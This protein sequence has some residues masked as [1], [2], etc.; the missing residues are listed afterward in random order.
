M[1]QP[2]LNTDY[3]RVNSA[4]H[5]AA[6]LHKNEPH[7]TTDHQPRSHKTRVLCYMPPLRDQ[8]ATREALR[9]WPGIVILTDKPLGD[10]LGVAVY[11]TFPG[12]KYMAVWVSGTDEVGIVSE[13]RPYWQTFLSTRRVPSAPKYE[14]A[15]A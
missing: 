15:L 14:L 4:K 2:N 10:G 13:D 7:N 1:T 9:R 11:F 5:V 12:G 6:R 3:A 8:G